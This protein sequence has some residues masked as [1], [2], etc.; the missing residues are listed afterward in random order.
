MC[1]NGASYYQTTVTA[2][3]FHY[4]FLSRLK[5]WINYLTAA[6]RVRASGF[7]SSLLFLTPLLVLS[8]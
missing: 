7:G 4:I 3:Q 1:D 2:F 5:V 8:F 6:G